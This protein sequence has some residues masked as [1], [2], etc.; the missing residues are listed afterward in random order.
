[1]S[2]A[3]Q[4]SSMESTESWLFRALAVESN[5]RLSPLSYKFLLW[6]HRPLTDFWQIGRGKAR[7]LEKAYMFTMGD[8][9]ARTQYDEEY[10]YKVFGIDGEILIDH[11][12]CIPW[13]LM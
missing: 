1:M 2:R 12:S 8:I 13:I 9:A 4:I 3:L 5:E 6:D 10:F 11:A 7:R